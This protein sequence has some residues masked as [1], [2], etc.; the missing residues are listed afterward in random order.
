MSAAKKNEEIKVR[1][2]LEVFQKLEEDAK[3][4]AEVAHEHQ[5]EDI[6]SGFEANDPCVRAVRKV[7]CETPQR[8]AFD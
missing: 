1:L 3:K 5:K 7:P 2:I 6:V 4:Q 8:K